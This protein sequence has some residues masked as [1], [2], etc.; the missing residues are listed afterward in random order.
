[1]TQHTNV[2]HLLNQELSSH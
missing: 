2:K 1:V